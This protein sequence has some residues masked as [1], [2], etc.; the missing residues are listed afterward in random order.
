MNYFNTLK[1]HLLFLTPLSLSINTFAQDP[2]AEPDSAVTSEK[3]NPEH[4]H[5]CAEPQ[6]FHHYEL[7]RKKRF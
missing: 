6:Y 2:C 4:K 7:E 3:N 1:L 5:T